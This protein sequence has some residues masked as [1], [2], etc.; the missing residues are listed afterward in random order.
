MKRTVV[1]LVI[2]V[3]LCTALVGCS[4]KSLN[5]SSSAPSG[6]DQATWDDYCSHGAALLGYLTQASKGTLTAGELADKLKGSENGIAGDASATTGAFSTKFQ[7]LA[8]AIGRVKVALLDG[9]TPDYSEI[10]TASNTI[11]TCNTQ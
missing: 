1:A 7:A 2:V 11:P 3:A 9:T 8:D 6:V 5:G 4:S 10:V